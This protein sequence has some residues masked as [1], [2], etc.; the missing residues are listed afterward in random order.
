MH[1]GGLLNDIN[2]ESGAEKGR[3]SGKS[4]E[5]GLHSLTFQ[6]SA[7]ILGAIRFAGFS[8]LHWGE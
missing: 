6:I 5:A 4:Q 3:G 8:F 2:I 7:S 1:A